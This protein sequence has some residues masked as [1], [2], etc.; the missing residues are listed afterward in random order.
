MNIRY[1]IWAI[2]AGYTAHLSSAESVCGSVVDAGSSGSRLYIHS[3]DLIN[4]ALQNCVVAHEQTVD[5]G[6]Q[7]VSEDDREL[8]WQSLFAN[9]TQAL[10]QQCNQTETDTPLV[11]AATAGMRQAS[12]EDQ[13][14][15]EQTTS[16]WID[17]NTDYVNASVSII[18]GSREAWYD[19][20]AV[21]TLYRK[22]SSDCS[23]PLFSV[24][25]VG[26]ASIEWAY[27]IN[28]QES[29]PHGE[30]LQF[31]QGCR[32][33]I[34]LSLSS[35]LGMGVDQVVA[36]TRD[37]ASCY[38]PNVP[39]VDSPTGYAQGNYESC[40][41]V[42]KS[43]IESAPF[44]FSV[45]GL[46]DNPIKGIS[47]AYYTAADLGFSDQPISIDDWDDVATDV[48]A[49]PTDLSNEFSWKDCVSA[50]L[51]RN[52]LF[53]P[54]SPREIETLHKINETAITWTLGVM[55][56]LFTTMN[57]TDVTESSSDDGDQQSFNANY[58]AFGIGLGVASVVVFAGT[59]VCL[60]Y[61]RKEHSDYDKLSGDT[62]TNDEDV[63]D[64]KFYCC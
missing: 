57:L 2:F 34:Q 15:F 20:L 18:P 43:F 41:G 59:L 39:I 23:S 26:G 35:W 49:Q 38:S 10:S 44:E 14:A 60:E 51:I 40:V 17:D 9:S 48:C 33:A 28:Q 11:I 52:V 6:W 55:A 24:I 62:Q 29:L 54:S 50:S 4:N 61:H 58:L 7:T 12:L 5:G 56:E 19:W 32:Y 27:E 8:Y 1:K 21:N 31:D 16:E 53:H 37:T 13:A 25:D 45:P 22:F 63:H 30:Q 36:E 42:V 3:C 47:A 64:R 46:L